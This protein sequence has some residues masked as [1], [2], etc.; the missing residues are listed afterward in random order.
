MTLQA[1]AGID[2][3][4]FKARGPVVS[5]VPSSTPR[6]TP[7]AHL[8]HSG[9]YAVDKK[10]TDSFPA[11]LKPDT[12][13]AASLLVRSYSGLEKEASYQTSSFCFT[14]N[15][16]TNQSSP[17]DVAFWF[18][19]FCPAYLAPPS[20]PPSPCVVCSCA[21]NNLVS[22]IGRPFESVNAAAVASGFTF[23]DYSTLSIP[24]RL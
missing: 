12:N 4:F 14:E 9:A 6:M 18:F 8:P 7:R 3:A 5:L 2:T 17:S 15:C 19:R 10:E 11:N 20:V 22:S 13:A 23:Y 16:Q 1:A 24:Q 21:P